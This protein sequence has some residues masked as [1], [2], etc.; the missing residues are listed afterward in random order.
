L[1]RALAPLGLI[2]LAFLAGCQDSGETERAAASA[3][4][5]A[6]T[7]RLFSRSLSNDTLRFRSGDNLDR[8]LRQA[9]SPEPERSALISAL[10]SVFDPGSFRA[11]RSL[12]LLRDEEDRTLGLHYPLDYAEDL[13][14]W[15]VGGEFRADRFQAQLDWQPRLLSAEL[16]NSFYESFVSQGENGDLAT[17]VADLFAGEIDFFFELRPGDCMEVLVESASR[18]DPIAAAAGTGSWPPACASAASGTRPI[19]SPARGTRSATSTATEAR[20]SGSSC[21]PP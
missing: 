13:C 18:P 2:A 10:V 17:R 12:V 14:A 1:S 16:E 9:G 19:S 6:A 4:A 7:R 21:A 15:R 5:P 8:L 11:G 3:S 20:W